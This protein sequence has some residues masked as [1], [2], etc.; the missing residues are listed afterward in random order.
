[1]C[2]NIIN[3]GLPIFPWSDPRLMRLPGTNRLGE[4]PLFL[5]CDKFKEQMRL[6]DKLVI[7]KA[8]KVCVFKPEDEDILRELR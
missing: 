4:D 5:I 1:M 3:D 6:R 2:N 8:N 7:T